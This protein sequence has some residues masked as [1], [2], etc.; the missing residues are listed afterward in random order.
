MLMETRFYFS[1]CLHLWKPCGFCLFHSFALWKGVQLATISLLIWLRGVVHFLKRLEQASLPQYPLNDQVGVEPTLFPLLEDCF[2]LAK[3]LINLRFLMS[4]L[5]LDISVFRLTSRTF[6]PS[7]LRTFA[8]GSAHLLTSCGIFALPTYKN[9]IVAAIVIT[10]VSLS[11]H[12]LSYFLYKY[13]IIKFY[14]N[15]FVSLTLRYFDEL[16]AITHHLSCPL[17]GEHSQ[18]LPQ[19]GL[20]TWFFKML[21]PISAL[22]RLAGCTSHTLTY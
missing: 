16:S 14:E 3:L 17:V 2:S 9:N 13:Y 7:G 11:L 6:F 20:S 12:L 22:T 4:Y 15:Q 10:N 21:Q 19:W 8:P 1:G 18:P 5:H